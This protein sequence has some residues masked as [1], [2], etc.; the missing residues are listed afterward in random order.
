MLDV[1]NSGKDEYAM[2]AAGFLQSLDKFN[3]Y[4]GLKLS[5]LVFSATE[6]FSTMLHSKNLTIQ[7]AVHGA[8]LATNVLERQRSEVAF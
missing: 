8:N 7:E 2:K 6:Q 4:Y 1:Q 5:H 3:T